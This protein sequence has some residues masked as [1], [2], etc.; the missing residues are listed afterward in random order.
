M[1]QCLGLRSPSHQPIEVPLGG[2][3]R[4]YGVGLAGGPETDRP[5][6]RGARWYNWTLAVW[7]VNLVRERSQQAG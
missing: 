5:P 4:D 2:F 7:S 1:T 3:K 6:G